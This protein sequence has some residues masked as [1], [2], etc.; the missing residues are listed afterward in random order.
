MAAAVAEVGQGVVLGED[1]DPRALA[2]AAARHPSPDRRLEPARRSLDLEAVGRERLR[3]GRRGVLLLERRLGM[4]VDP[5]RQIEDLVARRLDHLGQAP[6]GIGE[7]G[8][9]LDL[10]DVD[11]HDLGVLLRVRAPLGRW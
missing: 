9:R 1:P 10:R 6:L 7:R 3:H 5:M 4:G 11:G 2:R 8:G